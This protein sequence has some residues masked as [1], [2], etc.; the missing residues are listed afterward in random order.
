MKT[1]RRILKPE[2]T[3]S[4]EQFL[5][6]LANYTDEDAREIGY[7][8]ADILRLEHQL[9]QI[10]G[11]WRRTKDDELVHAYRGV[12]YEMILFGYDIDTLPIQD[13]LPPELMPNFPPRSVLAAVLN[14]YATLQEE[15]KES[16]T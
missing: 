6:E 9:T 15:Q 10:A 2:D 14:V 12:L 4:R 16:H 1:P 7:I 13:Q 5:K 11:K 8:N 3:K